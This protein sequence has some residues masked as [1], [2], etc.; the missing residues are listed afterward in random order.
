MHGPRES[1]F[2]PP[3]QEFRQVDVT[4][5]IAEILKTDH[6]ITLRLVNN[7]RCK[8]SRLSCVGGGGDF[9]S[10]QKAARFIEALMMM[11]IFT[12]INEQQDLAGGRDRSRA[13]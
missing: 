6:A 10:E 13:D 7:I 5:G 11:C 3:R 12:T 9:E 1:F 4:G 8:S 2:T